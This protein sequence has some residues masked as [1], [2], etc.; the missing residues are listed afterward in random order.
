LLFL[1]WGLGLNLSLG[2]LVHQSQGAV[3]N[4]AACAILLGL[5]ERLSLSNDPKQNETTPNGTACQDPLRQTKVTLAI[6]TGEEV[7]MQG[8]RAFVGDRNWPLPTV[9]VNL[10][11]MAQDGEYVF[12]EQDGNVFD[13]KTTSSQVNTALATTVMEVTGRSIHPAGPISSDGA[14]FLIAGI[15]TGVLGTYD[16]QWKDTGF[17]H[18]TDNLGRVAMARL[19]EGVEIAYRLLM[20][21]DQEG[22]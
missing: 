14:S 13:L 4:G 21:Y 9:A 19:P 20:R 16:T 3:D 7:Y 17:H 11:V 5:A 6:F 18:P 2:R 10:E 1:A 12:W 15:P 8:S 22:I